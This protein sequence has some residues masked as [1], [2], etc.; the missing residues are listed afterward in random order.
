MYKA[1]PFLGKDYLLPLYFSYIHSYINYANLVWAITHKTNL[2]KIH[3][4]HKHTLRIVYNKDRYH[5]IKEP[6]RSCNVLNVY[7]LNLLNGTGL[8]GFKIPSHSYPTR[9]SSV[10][11]RKPKTRLCKSNFRISISG[12]SIW[13]NFMEMYKCIIIVIV[14]YIILLVLYNKYYIYNIYIY[15]YIYI[16][17]YI[18][19]YIYILLVLASLSNFIGG[20]VNELV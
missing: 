13:N 18:Y 8:A 2:K 3:S 10:N 5:H 9:F 19:I 15:I 14:I 20:I 16:Y 7:K 4:H 17:L 11:Y 1:K 6:F 12:P